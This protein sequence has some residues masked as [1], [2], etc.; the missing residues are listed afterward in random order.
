M[1]EGRTC[2]EAVTGALVPLLAVFS[3]VRDDDFDTHWSE[4]CSIIIK[5]SIEVL[6]CRYVWVERGLALEI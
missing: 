2:I 5:G 6:S 4:W 3:L 1:F